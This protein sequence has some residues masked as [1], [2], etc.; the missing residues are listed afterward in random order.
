MPPTIPDT[1]R[2]TG[3]A[4]PVANVLLAHGAGADMDTPFMTAIAERLAARDV[5][6]VRFNFP[7]MIRAIA[8]GK[9]KPPDR[10]P[11]LR[12]AFET[13]L[14]AARSEFGNKQPWLLG[15]KSMGGRVA[16]MISDE[17]GAAGTICLGYPFHPQGKPEVRRTAHLVNLKTPT[18]ICQ[19]TRDRLGSEDEVRSYDLAETIEVCWL[20]DGDH[21]LKPRKKSGRTHDQNL[22]EAVAAITDFV[23]ARTT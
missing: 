1:W 4:Q 19:G 2:V 23:R 21:D 5:R 20:H 18:L 22:D 16:T 13:S 9:R 10:M 3:P 6:T 17:C 7:Y 12:E 11:A 14:A 15:G 8:A